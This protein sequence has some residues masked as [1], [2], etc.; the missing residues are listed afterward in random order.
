MYWKLQFNFGPLLFYRDE[1]INEKPNGYLFIAIKSNLV[2][3]HTEQ[4]IFSYLEQLLNL[5]TTYSF[6]QYDY[7]VSFIHTQSY[8]C[9][10]EITWSLINFIQMK[11]YY[12]NCYNSKQYTKCHNN[13]WFDD[14]YDVQYM[15]SK[16]ISVNL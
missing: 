12:N 13:V 9:N 4:L 15:L 10:F 3:S 6:A 2:I 7:H 16:D 8:E 1:S 11:A 14:S 5:E